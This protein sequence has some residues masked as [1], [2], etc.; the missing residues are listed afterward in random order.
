MIEWGSGCTSIAR[1]EWGV[2]EAVNEVSAFVCWTVLEAPM[3]T[4]GLL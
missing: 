2:A 4:T 3:S 1:R